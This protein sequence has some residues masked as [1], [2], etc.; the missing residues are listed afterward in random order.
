MVFGAAI[1]DSRAR[2]PVAGTAESVSVCGQTPTYT[3]TVDGESVRR[4][5]RFAI[6][7]AK[8]RPGFESLKIG[9]DCE[10]KPRVQSSNSLRRDGQSLSFENGSHLVAEP[11][12][13]YRGIIEFS[14]NFYRKIAPY[15][16]HHV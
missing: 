5:V 6:Q 9:R 1:R 12:I 7:S 13:L 10:G 8:D 2:V 15:L 14:D 16:F 4:D 3:A 11:P